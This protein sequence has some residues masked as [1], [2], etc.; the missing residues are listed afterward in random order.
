[1]GIIFVLR[2]LSHQEIR[3]HMKLKSGIMVAAAAVLFA[4]YSFSDKTYQPKTG[5]KVG[6][7]APELNF[8][9]PEGKAYKLSD[10]NKGRYVLIDFWA[11]WCRPCRM[12]NPT[13]VNA[14]NKF[15]DAKL[16]GAANGFT[17]YSLSL[18]RDMNSWKQAIT[19]DNLVWEYHVSDLGFW[20]S[21]G[22]VA[23]GVQSIPANYLLDPNGVIVAAN[24]RGPALEQELSKYLEN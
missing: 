24:L 7:K 20:N 2:Y 6:D 12:E 17:V 1:L 14:Y 5:T 22:A 15:K 8:K 16:K 11:S 23:Y 10:V 21:A 13:V 18:D 9:N 4:A 19:Q 3:K